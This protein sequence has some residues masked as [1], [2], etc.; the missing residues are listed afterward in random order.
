MRTETLYLTDILEACEAIMR[1]MQNVRKEDFLKD[2]LRLS[3]VLQKMIV[4]GEAAARLTSEFKAKNAQ[5]EWADIVG[6]RN[7]AVHEYFIVS[8]TIVW[9]TITD[10]IPHLHTKIA[11]I[12]ATQ[13][14]EEG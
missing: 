2:E 8:W 14:D 5:V 1:F 10:D 4:I 11:A 9:D 12:L 7:I 6:F 3:A 13:K